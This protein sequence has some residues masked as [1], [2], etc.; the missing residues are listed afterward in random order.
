MIDRSTY[1]IIKNNRKDNNELCEKN[2]PQDKSKNLNDIVIHLPFLARY[3]HIKLR[4]DI[5]LVPGCS[6]SYQQLIHRYKA[7][8]LPY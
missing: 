6:L 2:R 4:F 8:R 5:L 3:G 7:A 1:R